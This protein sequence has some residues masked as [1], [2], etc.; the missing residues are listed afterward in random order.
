MFIL[1]TCKNI[2]YSMKELHYLFQSLIISLFLYAIQVWGVAGYTNHLSLI[3]KLQKRAFRHKLCA[4][5][6]PICDILKEHDIKL[7]NTIRNNPKHQLY[8]LLPPVRSRSL[9]PRN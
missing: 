5:Y 7:W 9:R 4:E 2:G 1:R 6:T 8:E 3:D